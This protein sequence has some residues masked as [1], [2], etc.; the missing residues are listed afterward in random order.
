[1]KNELLGFKAPRK[2]CTDPKCPFHGKLNVKKELLRGKVIKKDSHRSAT[3]EWSRLHYIPKYE[4]FELRRSRLR[5]HNPL[6][7]D[8]QLGQEVIAARTRPL[9]KTK[10]HV[11]ITILKK[12]MKEKGNRKNP[13]SKEN[14]S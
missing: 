13:L 12:E 8:A 6:C 1:M 11:I 3:L 14:S 9:S 5:V 2:N 10:N 4:R 7:L